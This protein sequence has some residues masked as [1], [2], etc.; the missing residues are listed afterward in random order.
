MHEYI[1]ENTFY[2][3]SVILFQYDI[4]CQVLKTS[5]WKPGKLAHS[6]CNLFK[7]RVN[8]EGLHFIV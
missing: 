6:R 3:L 2:I 1:A 5:Q 4:K 7:I 8:L